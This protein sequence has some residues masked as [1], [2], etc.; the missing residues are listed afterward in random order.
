MSLLDVLVVLE[1]IGTISVQWFLRR[2]YVHWTAARYQRSAGISL[3]FCGSCALRFGFLIQPT[4]ALEI[5]GRKRAPVLTAE[6]ANLKVPHLA[7]FVGC[8]CTSCFQ[9]L[10]SLEYQSVTLD[11]VGHFLQR[12]AVGE[13]F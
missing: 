8:F 12:S 11:N 2:L 5:I 6:D 10:K 7:L 9:I 4:G 13:E 3:S 1:I